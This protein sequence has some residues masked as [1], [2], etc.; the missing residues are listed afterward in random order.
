MKAKKSAEELYHGEPH[1]NDE[2]PVN[3]TIENIGS[4]ALR[5]RG[6]KSVLATDRNYLRAYNKHSTHPCLHIPNPS[7]REKAE[8]LFIKMDE[9]YQDNR[10]LSPDE[11]LMNAEDDFFFNLY[12]FLTTNSN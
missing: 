2:L 5:E 7:D 6:L 4:R 8:T 11:I 10:Q 9:L 1:P 12:L 3:Q